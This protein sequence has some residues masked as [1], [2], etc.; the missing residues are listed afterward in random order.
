MNKILTQQLADFTIELVAKGSKFVA[1]AAPYADENEL[2]DLKILI[3]KILGEAIIV[4]KP[5]FN[6]YPE[7]L[8]QELRDGNSDANICAL[9]P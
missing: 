2:I 9:K 1:E 3:G 5:F 4:T 7:V 6:D 8:P